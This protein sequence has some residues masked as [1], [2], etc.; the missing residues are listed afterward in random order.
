LWVLNV[1]YPGGRTRQVSLR[2]EQV[3]Q[4]R[5]WIN[6]YHR[7]KETLEQISEFNQALLRDQR[8]SLKSQEQSE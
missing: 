5:E 8:E 3:P 2:P 4:A 7:L 6:N 1:I